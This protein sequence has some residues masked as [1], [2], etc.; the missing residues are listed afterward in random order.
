M[1]IAF[2]DHINAAQLAVQAIGLSRRPFFLS[3]KR[4]MVNLDAIALIF[5]G[6]LLTDTL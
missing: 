2:L 4:Q 3:Q 5:F 6:L 1:E